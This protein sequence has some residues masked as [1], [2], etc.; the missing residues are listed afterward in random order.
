MR[1]SKLA[2]QLGTACS[3][4]QQTFELFDSC[5]LMTKGL[6]IF[7]DTPGFDDTYKSDIEIL[8]LIAGWFVAVYK[9][10]I[11]LAAIVYLHRISDNRMAGSPLKNL[12]MVASMCGQAAMPRVILG[13][14]MWSE[15]PG[16]VAV[17]RDNELRNIFWK[18]ML[19][20][21][22]K[23]QPFSDSYESAWKM[24]GMLPTTREDVI[25]SSEIIEDKKRLNET[26]AGVMLNSELRRLIA[27][28][29]DAAVRLERQAR[30]EGNP[31][32]VAEMELRKAEIEKKIIGVVGQLQ[33][34]KIP[35]GR[36]TKA[37]FTRRRARKSGIRIPTAGAD[38]LPERPL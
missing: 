22:C 18:D 38:V 25:L 35:F 33:H 21:G 1:L 26:V 13:T 7:V 20:Q 4:K 30:T 8:S 2:H 12:I 14:T 23:V 16:D 17:R 6:V 32:L 34:L 24:I 9:E 28:Q 3:Q 19:A 15:V 37:F 10:H 29:K 31:V 11:P 5:I 36:K 27:D